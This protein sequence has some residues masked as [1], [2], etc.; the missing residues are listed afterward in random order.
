MRREIPTRR[1]D[2]SAAVDGPDQGTNPLFAGLHSLELDLR[3]DESEAGPSAGLDRAVELRTRL[4]GVAVDEIPVA[5]SIG[6]RRDLHLACALKVVSDREG[7]SDR[8]AGDQRPANGPDRGRRERAVRSRQLED[9]TPY[10]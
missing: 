5:Q 4:R 8:S 7:L 2:V 6:E 9:V 1:Q 10:P 3:H